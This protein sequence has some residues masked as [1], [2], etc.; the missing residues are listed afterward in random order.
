MNDF[1]NATVELNLAQHVTTFT[2]SDFS[3]TYQPASDG[4]SDH[5]WG[6]VQMII[7]SI[8]HPAAFEERMLKL[9]DTL[10][11]K[12][13]PAFVRREAP[14]SKARAV[15][16]DAARLLQ[17]VRHL[18]PAEEKMFLSIIKKLRRN[19]EAASEVLGCL[20]QYCQVRYMYERCHL[21]DPT[22]DRDAD[23]LWPRQALGEI[24]LSAAQ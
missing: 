4:G 3:R 21:W 20:L 12:H 24:E 18:G 10:G 17:R 22:V 15:V 19:R 1:Y 14:T 7:N 16:N 13:V 5:A 6:S 11:S 8:Y 2:M 23:T 9:I